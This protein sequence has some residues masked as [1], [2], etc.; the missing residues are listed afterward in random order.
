MGGKSTT[1]ERDAFASISLHCLLAH[2][3]GSGTPSSEMLSA[4]EV[5]GDLFLKSNRRGTKHC[6]GGSLNARETGSLLLE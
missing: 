5:W 2:T 1:I 4:N 3:A 6:P